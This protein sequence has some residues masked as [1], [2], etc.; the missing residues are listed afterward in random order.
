MRIDNTST[1]AAAL[2]ASLPLTAGVS[3]SG[4]VTTALH[5]PF[6]Q[7]GMR[8]SVDASQLRAIQSL[9]AE[10]VYST[11]V[12]LAVH[13]DISVHRT[14]AQ[15]VQAIRRLTGLP[16]SKI[17]DVFDVSRRTIHN[18]ASGADV[19]PENAR[20]IVS[21]ASAIQDIDR[22]TV[23]ANAALLGHEFSN[24]LTGF[25]LLRTQ[26]YD[27]FR[28]SFAVGRHPRD[29]SNQPSHQKRPV[30]A[31]AHFGD[32]TL[33]ASDDVSQPILPLK[34]PKPVRVKVRPRSR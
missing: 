16:W 5:T 23:A 15:S 20:R 18:W 11:S 13:V 26:A 22:G 12:P 14:P 8:R 33:S 17:A 6:P 21:V 10:V 30:N 25:E 7:L 24:G 32:E 19:A 29:T 27:A 9:Y 3:E 2:V 31:P 28:Q 1:A 4:V 34:K